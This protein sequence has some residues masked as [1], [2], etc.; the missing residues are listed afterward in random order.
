MRVVNGL[1]LAG[2][3]IAQCSSPSVDLGDWP[4]VQPEAGPTTSTVST[5][6][7]QTIF[8]GE[9]DRDGGAPSNTAWKAFGYDLDNL[10]TTKLST[11]VCTL[12]PG[13]F[14]GTQVDGVD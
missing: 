14:R 2:G 6:A 4:P 1:L 13:A 10:T 9:A 8:L 5:F 12:A 11:D 7:I 3:L